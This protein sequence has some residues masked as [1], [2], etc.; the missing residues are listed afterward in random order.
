M[1]QWRMRGAALALALALGLSGCGGGKT[2]ALTKFD[3][4]TY[5]D[6]LIKEN[7]LGQF[8]EDYLDL[9][10]ISREE[11]QATY[12][13]SMHKEAEFFLYLY[14]IEY[15]KEGLEEELIE[16]Y[17]E[18]Y[19]HTKYE[20]VSAA[21]Q[22]DGSFSVKVDVEPVDIVQQVYASW[23][24]NMKDFYE[25]YP[26]DK[27]NAMNDQEYEKYDQ[28]WTEQ[29]V[30]LYK[31]KLPETGNMTART[32][33]VQIEKDEDGYYSVT[34]ESFQQLDDAVIDYTDSAGTTA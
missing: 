28:A 12:E 10:G 1:R 3:A 7:Y 22:E 26:T 9:V 27:V 8:E 5:V 13:D 21:E 4:K 20:I 25:E 29:V 15:P 16:L 31:E 11:A 32:I 23:D 33:V 6:G 30:G 17:K 34:D 19:S 18:I 2:G 24:K 14:G